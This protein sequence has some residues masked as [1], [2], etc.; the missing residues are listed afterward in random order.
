MKIL[1]SVSLEARRLRPSVSDIVA[2][3]LVV[4][5]IVLFA[6]ASRNLGH[7]LSTT[8]ATQFQMGVAYLPG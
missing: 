6:Q 7:P 5:F 1:P 4:G 3:G 2:A 8:S